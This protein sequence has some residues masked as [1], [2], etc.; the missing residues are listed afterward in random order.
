MSDLINGLGNGLNTSAAV[1]TSKATSALEDKLT[2]GDLSN[3]TD[4]ELMEVCKDFEAYFV[5]QMFRAMEKMSHIT[6]EDE[7]DDSAISSGYATQMR[8]YFQD[9][10]LSKYAENAADSNNGSGLGIAQ[11]LYEQ[12][13]RNYNL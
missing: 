7:E 5:E 3:A 2:G 8:E 12:M 4:E 9:E 1:N 6:D 11:M 13:K 10:M